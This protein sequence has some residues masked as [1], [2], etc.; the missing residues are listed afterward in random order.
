M[1]IT[2]L[3]IVIEVKLWQLAKAP[4]PIEVTLFG[5]EMLVRLLQT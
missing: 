5:I 4:S 2:L 3:G 1:D